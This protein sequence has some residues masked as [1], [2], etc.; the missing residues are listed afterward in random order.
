M[1]LKKFTTKYLNENLENHSI[2]VDGFL[3]FDISHRM[4]FV[5]MLFFVDNRTEEILYKKG[6][7]IKVIRTRKLDLGFL[8]LT[9][10]KSSADQNELVVSFLNDNPSYWE[11]EDEKIKINANLVLDH[12]KGDMDKLAKY[13]EVKKT[14]LF[15]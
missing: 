13:F 14:D 9:D 11:V 3:N 8:M 10:Y 1:S 15:Y 4:A 5:N 2:S 7:R 12:R 6:I